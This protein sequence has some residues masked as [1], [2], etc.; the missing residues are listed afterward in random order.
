MKAAT[1]LLLSCV[2]ALALAQPASA[3]VVS[4]QVTLAGSSGLSNVD[5]DFIDRN[6][7]QSIPLTND[8]T[9]LLG[10]YAIVVPT[11]D[12]D[13][14]F[15]PPQGTAVAADELR[16]VRVES[17]AMTL[18]VALLPGSFVTGRRSPSWIST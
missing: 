14:R 13:V 7:G 8:D 12:Y 9:D 18:N 16:G 4:G 3:T 11:G 2:A 10:F 1:T 17:A 6:T 15:K 5:L